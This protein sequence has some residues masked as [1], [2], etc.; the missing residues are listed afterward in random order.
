MEDKLISASE[1]INTI[2]DNPSINGKN[3]A[4]VKKH[5]DDAPAVEVVPGLWESEC[6]N[7]Y[8]C[9]NCGFGRNTEVQIG[10]NFCPNCGAKMDGDG[11]G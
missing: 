10:W 6:R 11:N 9:S 3:F 5:I 8:K 1:L 2:R 4:M 7:R